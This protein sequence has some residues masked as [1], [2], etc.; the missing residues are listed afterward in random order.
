MPHKKSIAVK[1]SALNK[2]IIGSSALAVSVFVIFTSVNATK[3]LYADIHFLKGEKLIMGNQFKNGVNEMNNAIILQP[4]NPVYRQI[5]AENVYGF[6]NLNRG[7][8]ETVRADLLRQA[9]EELVKARKN[10]SNVND[11]DVLLSLVY[12]E[13]GRT[14][15]AEELKNKVLMADGVNVIYRLNLAYFFIGKNEL[16]SAKEQL[17]AVDKINF[18]GMNRWY[19]EAKYHLAAGNKNDA[20]A[21]CSKILVKEPNNKEVLELQKKA[22]ML[23]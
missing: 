11:C 6:V 3:I 16:G 23:P 12:Y 7:I 17:E 4:E 8:K 18:L 1:R 22:N 14:K 2:L 21:A 5:L 19:V 9:A 13:S 10:H 15:E 20:L